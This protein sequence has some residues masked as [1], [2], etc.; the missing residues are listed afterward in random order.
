MGGSLR[1]CFR[2]NINISHH[3]QAGRLVNIILSRN[4]DTFSFYSG[5][6]VCWGQYRTE[7]IFSVAFPSVASRALLCSL[8]EHILHLCPKESLAALTTKGKDG[9]GGCQTGNCFNLE[10]HLFMSF[11]LEHKT[12]MATE[13][14]ILLPRRNS[15]TFFEDYIFPLVSFWHS[16]PFT[17]FSKCLPA[18][19]FGTYYWGSHW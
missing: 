9:M 3:N 7:G 18:P 19:S 10:S 5:F 16:F 8:S 13:D 1:H 17:R 4:I 15:P 11:R 2:V 14:A 6:W 12:K